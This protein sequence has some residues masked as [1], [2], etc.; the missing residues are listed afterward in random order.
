M[1]LA[2]GCRAGSVGGGVRGE[3]TCRRPADA[4]RGPF[5]NVNRAPDPHADAL[6][7][8]HRHRDGHSDA[9]RH[10]IADADPYAASLAATRRRDR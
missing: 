2:N 4:Q 3:C 8:G 7:N 10:A 6:P 1:D 9:N 5:C